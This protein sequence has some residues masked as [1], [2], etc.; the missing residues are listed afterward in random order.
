MVKWDE[1]EHIH[2]IKK[3][4]NI[5]GSWWNVD[6]I[7]TND[8]GQPTTSDFE[9]LTAHNPITPDLFKQEQLTKSFQET[10][11]ACVDE[12]K[13]TSNRYSVKRWE[14]VGFDLIVF[15]IIIE[16]DFYGGCC[17]FRLL[18]GQRR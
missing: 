9:K 8:M 11:A 3:L 2:V 14:M 12:L 10:V 13:L 6:V 17:C 5:I 7:F 1:F 18:K 4:K 15:P 16:N